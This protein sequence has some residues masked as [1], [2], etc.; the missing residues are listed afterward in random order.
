M[1][2][3][4]IWRRSSKYVFVF[5]FLV[6]PLCGCA[7][8]SPEPTETLR[9]EPAATFTAFPTHDPGYEMVTF[10]ASDGTELGG[11]FFPAEGGVTVVFTHMGYATQGSWREFAEQINDL[12]F[13]AFTFDF[14]GYGHSFNDGMLL[15]SDWQTRDAA[16]AEDARAAIQWVREQGYTRILCI[17]ADMGGTACIN[18][19]LTE[20]LEGLVVIG[21]E[22]NL[23]N[24]DLSYPADLQNPAAQKLF[25]T[26]ALDEERYIESIQQLYEISPE[27]RELITLPGSAHGT[28]ILFTSHEDAFITALLDFMAFFQ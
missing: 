21:S 26:T 25:I 16:Y 13:P 15:D 10:A 23:D 12:G 14:R 18:A 7:P 6:F 8:S 1:S 28:G 3:A 17:G 20:S 9:P 19:A 24:S 4:G 5:L 2:A 27:P 11:T 22:Y